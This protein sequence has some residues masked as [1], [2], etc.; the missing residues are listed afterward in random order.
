MN[1][2][3]IPF[4]ICGISIVGKNF[5]RI[6]NQK[7][8]EMI[9][10][11]LFVLGFLLFY[12]GFLVVAAYTSIRD[13]NYSMLIFSIPFWL[14]GIYL[15][16]KRLLNKNSKNNGGAAVSFSI[17]ISAVLIVIALLAGVFLLVLG[18]KDANLVLLFGGVIFTF[19]SLTFVLAALS[20]QGCFD[21][22]KIDVLG[23][24]MG[25]VIVVIGAGF[26][27]LKYVESYS[28]V[29]TVKAFGLWMIIPILMI[30]AGVLQ[31]I[32]CVRNR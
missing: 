32:K 9:F 3:L 30:L 20:I 19:G 21:K 4:V 24:Y 10:G 11:K 14:V 25:I 6:F 27:V 12:M 17:I 28:L 13:K 5:A 7:K 22:I 18:I 8:W 16:K 23:L 1:I 26:L 31:I 2:I 29:E 15:I